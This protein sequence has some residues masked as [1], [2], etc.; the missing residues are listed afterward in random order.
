MGAVDAIVLEEVAHRRNTGDL[1]RDDVLGI[2]FRTT[3][4]DGAPMSDDERCDAMRTLLLAATTPPLRRLLGCSN[5][6]PATHTSSLAHGT[7]RTRR[8]RYLDAVSRRRCDCD[9]WD[10]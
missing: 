10:R 6:S 8:R 1:D 7:L 4:D 3:D 9:Q 2:F 5:S